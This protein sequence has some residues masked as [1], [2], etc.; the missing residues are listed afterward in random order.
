MRAALG[1]GR[2]QLIGQVLAESLLIAMAGGVLG[3][4]L[5]AWILNAARALGTL[6]VAGMADIHLDG[7]MLAFT[8]A[9]S[10]ATGV[11]MALIPGFQTS[12]VDLNDALRDRPAAGGRR[13]EGL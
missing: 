6:H 3:S 10:I 11:M 13:D 4:V 5:A 8:L 12:R 9:A 2:G 7:A 1:A